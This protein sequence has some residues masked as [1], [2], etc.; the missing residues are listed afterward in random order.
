MQKITNFT[1]LSLKLH[2]IHAA[3][4]NKGLYTFPRSW[5]FAVFDVEKWYFWFAAG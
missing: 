1:K 5:S 3:A 2:R 4:L